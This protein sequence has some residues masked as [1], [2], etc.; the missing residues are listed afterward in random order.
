MFLL[1]AGNV[2]VF[3]ISFMRMGLGGF[4]IVDS[5]SPETVTAI[6]AAKRP[7]KQQAAR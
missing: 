1:S 2:L 5:Q 4:F 7:D 3:S 6:H